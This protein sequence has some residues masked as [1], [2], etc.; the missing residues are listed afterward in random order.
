[1]PLEKLSERN[2]D[3]SPILEDGEQI[4]YS[5][6]QINFYFA[7]DDNQG[8]GTL[9]IT[10]KRVIWLHQNEKKGYSIDFYHLMCHAISREPT[11]HFSHSCIYCQLDIDD[12]N[13]FEARFV[14]EGT[15][16]FFD[17]SEIKLTLSSL[18]SS[19]LTNIYEALCECAALNP[20]PVE[21]DEGEFF[22]NEDEV[23]FGA[24]QAKTLEHLESV[25]TMPTQEELDTLLQN[26]EQF[27]DAEEGEE[28]GKEIEDEKNDE[29]E[30]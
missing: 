5:Q 12:P 3:G 14:P 29:M 1:M 18:D 8:L 21:E 11:T 22:F 20:D 28:N 26:Q 4:H 19:S 9:F 10:N 6:P 24:E 16:S 2:S 17:F 30:S 23:N 27:E 7:V 15:N 13:Y 25:F